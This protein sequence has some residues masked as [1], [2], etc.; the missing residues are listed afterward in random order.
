MPSRGIKA[1]PV[2]LDQRQ[3]VGNAREYPPEQIEWYLDRSGCPFGLL[4]NGRHWRLV[5]RD[6]DRRL[7]RFKTFLEVDL[8][9]LI[10]EMKADGESLALGV[11]GQAFDRFLTFFLLFGRAGHVSE[12]GRKALITRAIEGSSVYALGVGDEL[13]G[14]V[15]E[16]LQLSIEGFLSL[17]DNELDPQRDLP[18]LREQSLVLLYRMLFTMFAEDRGLL[19]YRSN[20]TYT[21]NRSLARLR[22]E[23][24]VK[25]DLIARRLDRTDYSKSETGLWD[26]LRDLFDLIDV[27]NRRY[28]VPAYNGGLFSDEGHQFLAERSIADFYMARVIDCLG[29]SYQFNRAELGL[30]RVDYRDLAIQQLGAVYEGLIELHPRFAEEE[31]IVISKTTKGKLVEKI[32]PAAELPTLESGFRPTGT[33]YSAGSVYLETDKGERQSTGSY[34]TPDNIVNHMVAETIGPKC[35]EIGDQLAAEIEALEADADAADRDAR[36]DEL[37]GAFDDRLL[38]LKILDPSM[39]SGHFLIRV[40]QFLAEEIATHPY[41]RDAA[42][43][44]S[45][46][47]STLTYWKRRVAEN[48]LYGVD[49]N[50]MAVELAKLALWLE[51]ASSDAPL[52]FLDHHL[53]HGDS[54][55]GARVG[56]L[57]ELPGRRLTAGSFAKELRKALPSLLAPLE[58]I[59]RKQSQTVDEVKAKERNF[60]RRFRGA[61]ERFAKVADLWCATALGITDV[62]ASDYA[63]LL[64]ELKAPARFARAFEETGVQ[65]VLDALRAAG[66]AP[67]HWQLAFPD[68]L[69][70]ANPG[71]DVVIGNPPY[72]VVSERENGM[73]A[74]LLK[75]FAALDDSLAPS[76][77][78]KNNLYKLF[79]CRAHE[80]TRTGGLLSF[81]VPMPLLG[82]GQALGV[83]TLLLRGGTFREIHAFPQKDNARLR[84]FKD[85]KLS[86]CVFEH[87]KEPADAKAVFTSY[88]HPANE[89]DLQSPHLALSADS[90]EAFDAANLTIPSGDEVD[91]QLA[92]RVAAH[93]AF[94]TL[95]A[96]CKSFQGEINEGSDKSLL[97]SDDAEG[98]RL[99][100]RGAAVTRYVLRAASQGELKYLDEAAYRS[101]RRAER[102]GHHRQTRVGFQRSA[103]QNNYRRLIATPIPAGEHCFDTI[104]YVPESCSRL[105]PNMLLALLNSE[106]LEWYFRIS[107]TNSKVNEYQF[108]RLPCPVFAEVGNSEASTDDILEKILNAPQE[109]RQHLR[110]YIKSTPIPHIVA[111]VLIA[112]VNHIRRLEEERGEIMRNDRADLD[113]RAEAVQRAIDDILFDLAGFADREVEDLRVRLAYML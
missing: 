88:V 8:P 15:F 32:V 90:I 77:V 1:W 73:P 17:P 11:A 46:E 47:A 2:K 64:G 22:D 21:A 41:T 102:A 9:A 70:R 13:K 92:Q 43:D 76:R 58:E 94:S 14:R 95:G 38:Q 81:I 103:P 24:A 82:D 6:A 30:L 3:R 48:C 34:Y 19:P 68:V 29:R 27:G 79:I 16:A 36:L 67:F 60:E 97:S 104:S 72:D 62:A 111:D 45:S 53:Q 33:C 51:T 98:R 110:P 86:T 84:V 10:A 63:A 42:A 49:L 106:L 50:A 100:L 5:P 56:A 25:L 75:R 12:R 113:P 55:I 80:L 39:G 31:M 20:A 7:P 44:A 105:H 35:R 101:L 28:D 69:L 40:C 57:N 109:A 65:A 99:V 18:M 78:L 83:R 96:Y 91:W 87:R 23:V 85:A 26:G 112:L 61:Q 37:R 66:M 107:S 74:T 4:T 54:L 93:P 71:F 89:I 59:G 108:N 52:T